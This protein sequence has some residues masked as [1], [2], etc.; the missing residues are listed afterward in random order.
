MDEVWSLPSEKPNSRSNRHQGKQQAWWMET[1][2]RGTRGCRHPPASGG[3]ATL[4]LPFLLSSLPSLSF[5]PSLSLMFARLPMGKSIWNVQCY[6]SSFSDFMG[7]C[8][9]KTNF[10][11]KGYF[12][13]F[14]FTKQAVRIFS[15]C[16]AMV[17][18]VEAIFLVRNGNL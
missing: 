11:I 7:C 9:N 4:H 6:P 12:Q 16:V 15:C 1:G 2:L 17:S 14:F 3:A 10:S 18:R 8:E 13:V 5:S